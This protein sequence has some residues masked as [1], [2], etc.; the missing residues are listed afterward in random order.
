[1]RERADSWVEIAIYVIWGVAAAL[2]VGGIYVAVHFI[3]KFW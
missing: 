3:R 1:M 2:L